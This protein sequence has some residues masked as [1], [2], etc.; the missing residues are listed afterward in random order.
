MVMVAGQFRSLVLLSC[1]WA[2]AGFKLRNVHATETAHSAGA[3]VEKAVVDA[4]EVHRVAGLLDVEKDLETDKKKDDVN[5]RDLE[6]QIVSLVHKRDAAKRDE[7]RK[8]REI[9]FLQNQI[10]RARSGASTEAAAEV[11]QESQQESQKADLNVDA[12]IASADKVVKQAEATEVVA[13]KSE[14]KVDNSAQ[15][16][17]AAEAQAAAQKRAQVEAAAA[18]AAAAAS[19]R[20]EAA[21]KAE[22]AAAAAVEAEKKKKAEVAAAEA[23]E[24]RVAFEARIRQEAEDKARFKIKAEQEAETRIRTESEAKMRVKIEAENAAKA[25][26]QAESDASRQAEAQEAQ[27]KKDALADSADDSFKQFMK[28]EDGEDQMGDPDYEDSAN[29]L[30]S[31]IGWDRKEIEKKADSAVKQ[32]TEAIGGKKVVKSLQGMMAGVR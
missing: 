2:A 4:A 26:A 16:A 20:A 3:I 6:S 7:A 23:A 14:A 17:A 19:A 13:Q 8:D 10:G 30:S 32:L 28:E 12:A 15:V 27:K 9:A 5:L 31:A 29:A 24:S 22:A 1:A 25:K 11:A 21:A 18:A